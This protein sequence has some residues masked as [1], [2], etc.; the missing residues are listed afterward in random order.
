MKIPSD[1]AEHLRTALSPEDRGASAL[2]ISHRKDHLVQLQRYNA[3]VVEAGLDEPALRERR[4][5]ALIKRNLLDNQLAAEIKRVTEE[6]LRHARLLP[7]QCSARQNAALRREG[8]GEKQVAEALAV[9]H[10]SIY[11]D[12]PPLQK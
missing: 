12:D 9:I 7:K 4:R 11:G 8:I 5:A 3:A 1:C 2:R 10:Q 6:A